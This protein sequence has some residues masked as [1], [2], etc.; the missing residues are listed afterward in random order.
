MT[1][2]EAR[3]QTQIDVEMLIERFQ[4]RGKG[5]SCPEILAIKVL[6][7]KERIFFKQLQR[8]LNGTGKTV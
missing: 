1:W 7:A 5:G 3:Q 6:L 2:E 4:R 8:G